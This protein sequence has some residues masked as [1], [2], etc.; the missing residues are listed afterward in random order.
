MKKDTKNIQPQSEQEN[1]SPAK[2]RIVAIFGRPNVGKSALFNRI[3]KKRL[4]IVH[5]QSGVTRD[6]MMLEVNWLQERFIL[7]DTG[8]ITV[9][10]TAQAVDPIEAG[11]R[12]QVDAALGDAALAILV[13]D[14]QTGIHPM[15]MEVA[16][17]LRQKNIDCVVAANK[18]DEPRHEAGAAEFNKL[19]FP[20]YEVSA[21]HNRGIEPLMEKVL[22]G[23][24]PSSD[25]ST[26]KPLR[27]VVVGRPNAGK[28]SYI[29]RLL[30]NERVIVSN[31]PGTTRDS[32]EIPFTIGKGEQARHYTLIDTAGMRHVHK[33]DNA[34]ERFSLFRTEKSI[35]SADIVVLVMD[36]TLGPTSQDK[37]IAAKIIELRKGCVLI[38]NKWDAAREQ[39]MTETKAEPVIR[40]MLPFM[41]HCPLLFTSALGGYNVRR[42]ID[43][44]DHVAAQLQ[45]RLP[46]GILNR[47]IIEATEK[48]PPKGIKGKKLRIYYAL[49]V[50]VAPP[51]LRLFVN[52]PKL[53]ARTYTDYLTRRIRERFGLE[54]APLVISYRA[55]TRPERT[56]LKDSSLPS[57]E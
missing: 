27:V 42:S 46:T 10:S 54:G 1:S 53:V 31:I 12:S 51:V 38:M 4:A 57:E 14:V 25:E 34:V 35:A 32:I 19:G 36:A 41:N 48:A 6:R 37:H 52:D 28:S 13:V 9:D 29:N 22:A 45:T 21:E 40:A 30:K 50:G 23:L 5:D 3:A 26:L 33:I 24:P 55:R 20:V 2:E 47:T 15:D 56:K 43:V 16:R 49:Q 8:G 11:I 7:V 18:C 44:I 39:R 17:Q